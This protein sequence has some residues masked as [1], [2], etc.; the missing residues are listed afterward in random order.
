[1][2]KFS[3]NS[4]NFVHSLLVIV[5]ETVE[6]FDFSIY[7]DVSGVHISNTSDIME[8]ISYYKSDPFTLINIDLPVNSYKITCTE[9]SE[10]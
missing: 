4:L 2:Q 7:N 6:E 5:S 10:F 8:I 3:S 1:M 9:K